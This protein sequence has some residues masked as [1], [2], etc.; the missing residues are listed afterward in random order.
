VSAAYFRIIFCWLAS[1]TLHRARIWPLPIADI[2][3]SAGKQDRF[4]P[5]RMGTGSVSSNCREPKRFIAKY[6][7]RLIKRILAVSS[8]NLSQVRTD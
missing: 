5:A 6:Q 8:N 3:Y 1:H 7:C 4:N 2:V